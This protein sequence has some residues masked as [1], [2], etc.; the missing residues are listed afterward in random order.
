MTFSRMMVAETNKQST[1]DLNVK[2]DSNEATSN[3]VNMANR[4][5]TPPF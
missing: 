3:E 4:A 2:G 5:T 1:K